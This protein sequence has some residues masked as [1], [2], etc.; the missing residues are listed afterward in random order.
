MRDDFYKMVFAI[1]AAGIL[2]TWIVVIQLVAYLGK[3]ICARLQ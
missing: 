2:T 3:D 1:F